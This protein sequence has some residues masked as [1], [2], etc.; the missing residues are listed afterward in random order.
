MSNSHPFYAGTYNGN[1]CYCMT[2]DDRVKRVAEFNLEQCQAVLN[3]PGL[4]TTVRAA[5]ERRIRKLSRASQ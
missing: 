3:L 1:D 2:A 5:A 4:Q